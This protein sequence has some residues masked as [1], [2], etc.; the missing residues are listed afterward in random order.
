[1]RRNAMTSGMP[2]GF[3]HT[4]AFVHFPRPLMGH[5]INQAFKCWLARP[6]PF[7]LLT[8]RSGLHRRAFIHKA[9]S[10]R[11]RM[12]SVAAQPPD[13]RHLALITRASRS[14]ARSPCHAP[15][16]IRFLLTDKQRRSTLP[17]HTRS[18]SCSCASLRSLC[19]AHGRTCTAKSAP[20]PGVRKK[21][22][23]TPYQRVGADGVI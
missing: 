21:S 22:A 4:Q 18:P 5:R 9:R 14:L 2:T 17:R 12:H 23:P 10:P 6:D 16:Y 11:I 19:S 20:V 7:S 1:V 8:S 13:L 3:Q 15:A